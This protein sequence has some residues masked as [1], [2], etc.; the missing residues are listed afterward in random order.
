MKFSARIRTE[1]APLLSQST[2][3]TE[4]YEKTFVFPL[5]KRT[6]VRYNDIRDFVAFC[7]IVT[8]TEY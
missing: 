2:D 4:K 8:K 6:F 3:K 7:G 5:D 1:R